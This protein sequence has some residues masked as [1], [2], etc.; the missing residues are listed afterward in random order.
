AKA[1]ASNNPVANEAIRYH[2]QWVNDTLRGLERMRVDA[3]PRHLEALLRFAARAYRKPLSQAERDD[4]LAYYHSLREK[5]GLTHEEAVR[6]SIV[7]LLMSPKFCYR[8]D[9][10]D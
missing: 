9:L 6:D 1:A 8:I 7:S 10:V 3:E 5:N 2:F 4:T